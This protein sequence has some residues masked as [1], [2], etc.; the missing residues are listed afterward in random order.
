MTTTTNKPFNSNTKT[1]TLPLSPS[2][3]PSTS[4]TPPTPRLPVLPLACEALSLN[5]LSI[6]PSKPNFFITAY[7]PK[8]K[9]S[10]H[11]PEGFGRTKQ[12]FAAE[13]DIN[14]IMARYAKT[15]VLDF[16]NQHAPQYADC[17]GIEFEAG[18][19]TIAAAKSM[20]ADLPAELRS[21]FEND[22]A[23]FLDFVN[24]D[25]NHE[26]AKELG[27][28]RPE[29]APATPPHTPVKQDAPAAP[30]VP[31][32]APGAPGKGGKA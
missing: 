15:G 31:P 17:T 7:G 6:S 12:S 2:S 8:V 3:I 25:R 20:F 21:R 23:Q 24:D 27:L 1:P 16:A 28:L 30:E 4:T 5:T 18:M 32:A 10:Q 19:Q 29:P 26:E 22:P 13:C 9:V 14:N 11:F